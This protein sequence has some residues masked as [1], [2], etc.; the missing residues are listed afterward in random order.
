MLLSQDEF[1]FSND[2]S[3][4]LLPPGDP[5]ECVV[6]VRI[7]CVL[8]IEHKGEWMLWLEVCFARCVLDQHWL[9][10]SFKM[11][12]ACFY[13]LLGWGGWTIV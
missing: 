5:H 1:V 6:V 13:V 3:I 10:L 4:R 11:R 8:S 9:F 12:E 7:V 2:Q